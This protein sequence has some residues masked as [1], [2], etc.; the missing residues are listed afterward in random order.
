MAYQNGKKIATSLDDYNR[1]DIYK[2]M[3]GLL[4]T[5]HWDYVIL[6]APA[7]LSNALTTLNQVIRLRTDSIQPPADTQNQPLFSRLRGHQYTQPGMIDTTGQLIFSFQDRA[8]CYVDKLFTLYG[9]AMSDPYYKGML[10]PA[11]EYKWDFEIMRYSP[12]GQPVKR[13]LCKDCSMSQMNKDES[14]TGETNLLG[15]T[16]IAFMVD[17]NIQQFFNNG[18]WEGD[19]LMDNNVDSDYVHKW[20]LDG[21]AKSGDYSNFYGVDYYNWDKDQLNGPLVAGAKSYNVPSWSFSSKS[22]STTTTT[23]DSTGKSS[24]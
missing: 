7:I 15:L 20:V 14:M 4:T 24:S 1:S 23:T 10:L 9:Y 13:W 12:D 21:S 19:F 2:N 8:D 3:S 17:H 11:T 5:Y 6:K 18:K 16:S 22:T